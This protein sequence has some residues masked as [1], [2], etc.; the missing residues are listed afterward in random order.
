M[1]KK[2]N[3]K[4]YENGGRCVRPYKLSGP[5]SR[6]DIDNCNGWERF[7]AKTKN[8]DIIG[9]PTVLVNTPEEKI[10][11]D[12]SPDAPG[13]VH[14][15]QDFDGK[16]HKFGSLDDAVGAVLQDAINLSLLQVMQE[17]VPE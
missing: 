17:G 9:A 8:K 14:A 3:C 13:V 15:Y 2:E 6:C 12:K 11:C 5:L 16:I 7:G 1:A 4:H 10:L